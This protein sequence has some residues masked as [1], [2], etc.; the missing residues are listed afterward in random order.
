[1]KIASYN[2]R[3]IRDSKKCRKIFNYMHE[4][5]DGSLLQETHSTKNIEKLWSAKFG[6][7]IMFSHGESNARG[8]AICFS[9]KVMNSIQIL[10][11]TRDIQGRYILIKLI[12]NEVRLVLANCY[13]PNHDDPDFFVTLFTEIE[14]LNAGQLIL[15]GDFNTT[16]SQKDVK[17]G[18]GNTHQ[19]A[20]SYINN[21]MQEN[22]IEDIWHNRYPNL[23]RYTFKRA[24][25][26]SIMER[27]DYFLVSFTM[28]QH[29]SNATI[30][31][32]YLSDHSI[33]IIT[34]DIFQDR[35][36]S[37]YWKFNT[38]LL[39]DQDYLEQT[40]QIISETIE[41]N[42]DPH[43]RWE[44]IKMKVRGF[45]IQ[46][47]SRKAKSRSKT[48]KALEKKLA[49][50]CRQ[51]AELGILTD[52][53]IKQEQLIRKDIEKIRA[54]K[55]QGAIIRMK[56]QWYEYSERSSKYFFQL[57][58]NKSVNRSINKIYD[59]RGILVKGNEAVTEALM[60]YY[61]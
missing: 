47:S 44:M 46:Y 14:K 1:M 59:D 3:G 50:V 45:T 41:E 23:F 40:K 15:A 53:A 58:K 39:K 9:K 57:E 17:G 26:I 18:K 8:V 49:Q 56:S 16:L 6:T 48:L 60:Q 34:L 37:D 4:R 7:K 29:I 36:C 31:P 11:I 38:S 2:V 22:Q 61:K 20:T 27:L 10:N 42:T 30:S 5:F 35:F 51:Q 13:A 28:Q 52:S 24:K 25:P 33:P 19:K 55:T 21:Y 54:Y 12:M 32:S 43:L